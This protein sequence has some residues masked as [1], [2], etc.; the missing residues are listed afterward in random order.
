[1]ELLIEN[2]SSGLMTN[3]LLVV[4]G[5]YLYKIIERA[6]ELVRL[7]KGPRNW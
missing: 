6:D 4:I 2:L 1:M 7:I 3:T 5:I